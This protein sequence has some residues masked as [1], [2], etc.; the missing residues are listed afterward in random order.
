MG[1]SENTT[2]SSAW[3][4]ERMTHKIFPTLTFVNRCPANVRW[5]KKNNSLKIH[6]R[7]FPVNF[8]LP[9]HSA[10]KHLFTNEEATDRA[11]LEASGIR[12]RVYVH[13]TVG[14]ALSSPKRH[15]HNWTYSCCR[16]HAC[17][18]INQPWDEIKFKC[19]ETPKVHN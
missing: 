12:E 19:F 7:C 18:Q 16:A 1:F 15:P 11:F 9:A 13:I 4:M 17:L 8:S 6:S 5:G 14:T 3:R 10:E 2:S